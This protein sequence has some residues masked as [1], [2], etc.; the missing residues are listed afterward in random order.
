MVPWLQ[1][2]EAGGVGGHQQRHAHHDCATVMDLLLVMGGVLR[3]VHS[4]IASLSVSASVWPARLG[5]VYL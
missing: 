5:M 3:L 1:G 2:E 4:L